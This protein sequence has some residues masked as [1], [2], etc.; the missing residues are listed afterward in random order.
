MKRF[1]ILALP[2]LGTFLALGLGTFLLTRSHTITIR[3]R[4]ALTRKAAAEAVEGV[5][6]TTEEAT[7]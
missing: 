7:A 6:A 4:F 1:V 3:P 2:I 5:A